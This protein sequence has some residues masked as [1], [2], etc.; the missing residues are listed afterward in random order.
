MA[1][2]GTSAATEVSSV[3]ET[4]VLVPKATKGLKVRKSGLRISSR[5]GTLRS[6][7]FFLILGSVITVSILSLF[8]IDYADRLASTRGV[9]ADGLSLGQRSPLLRR[10]S[11]QDYEASRQGLKFGTPERAIPHA[12]SQM[13]AME[14]AIK[15]RRSG[16]CERDFKL[17]GCRGAEPLPQ[18]EY[19]F[20][21]GRNRCW[22][23]PTLLGAPIGG[24]TRLR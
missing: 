11:R 2:V 24:L 10:G 7:G 21:L 20:R 19:G 14:R 16:Q 8:S 4:R 17:C 18:L 12:I 13:H 1:I 22:R 3:R 5:P 23:R 6:R 9:N 15:A